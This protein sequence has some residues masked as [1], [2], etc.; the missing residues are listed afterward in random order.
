LAIT[1]YRMGKTDLA[2]QMA[3]KALTLSISD[4]QEEL[5]SQ[6]RSHLDSFKSSQFIRPR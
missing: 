3:E 4:N 2:I 5:T 1:H 6:I